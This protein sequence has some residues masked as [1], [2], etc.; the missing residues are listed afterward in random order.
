M[1][2]TPETPHRRPSRRSNPH[3]EPESSP[4]TI[5]LGPGNGNYAAFFFSSSGNKPNDRM[6]ICLFS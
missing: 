1:E 3:N 5:L 2:G 4:E 6:A